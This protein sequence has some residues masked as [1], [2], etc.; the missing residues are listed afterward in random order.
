MRKDC[1]LWRRMHCHVADVLPLRRTLVKVSGTGS[2]C[3]IVAAQ[4]PA[5]NAKL[6]ALCVA[7]SLSSVATLIHDTYLPLYLQDVLGL[8]NTKVSTPAIASAI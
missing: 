5:C 8:S 7:G 2:G 1:V 4:D 3:S 6:Q